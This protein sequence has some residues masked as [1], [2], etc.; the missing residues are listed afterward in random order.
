MNGQTIHFQIT[1]WIRCFFFLESLN[2]KNDEKMTSKLDCESRRQSTLP[3]TELIR[4]SILNAWIHISLN[5]CL[6]ICVCARIWI[7]EC[8]N[9]CGS[10]SLKLG[11]FLHYSPTHHNCYFFSSDGS[12][13]LYLLFTDWYQRAGQ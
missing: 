5:A 12:L 1:F 3:V 7:G 8:A 2:L 10:Y 4:D 11:V 6:S 13:S 9:V